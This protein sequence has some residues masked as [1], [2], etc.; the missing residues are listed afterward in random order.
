MPSKGAGSGGSSFVLP[1]LI[2]SYLVG[3]GGS[4]NRAAIGS[5]VTRGNGAPGAIVLKFS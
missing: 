1:G 4:G 3:T 2:I 5:L